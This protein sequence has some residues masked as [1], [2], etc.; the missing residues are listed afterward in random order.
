MIGT[1]EKALTKPNI[2]NVHA[3]TDPAQHS[4]SQ[5][6]KSEDRTFPSPKISRT[7]PRDSSHDSTTS[8]LSPGISAVTTPRA[9]WA[10]EESSVLGE[11]VR[12]RDSPCKVDVGSPIVCNETAVL[13]PDEGN[14]DGFSKSDLAFSRQEFAVLCPSSAGSSFHRQAFGKPSTQAR[15]IA[16]NLVL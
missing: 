8:R 9:A 1:L 16:A 7:S 12:E 2:C 15:M 14:E 13:T 3:S 11:V 6:D 10:A 5:G 4:S